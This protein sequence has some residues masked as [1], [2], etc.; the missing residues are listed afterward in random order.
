MKNQYIGENCLKSGGS[1]Y[2]L[3]IYKGAWQKGGGVDNPMHTMPF[4][5][6]PRNYIWI[7]WIQR[8]IYQAISPEP[9]LQ[10]SKTGQKLNPIKIFNINIVD[11]GI[12]FPETCAIASTRAGTHVSKFMCAICSMH[13]NNSIF[14]FGLYYYTF[15]VINVSLKNFSLKII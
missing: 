6:K 14:T 4:G 15:P 12:L 3:Q 11:L 9:K 13:K 8:R 2:S 10:F 1:L 5:L 7:T